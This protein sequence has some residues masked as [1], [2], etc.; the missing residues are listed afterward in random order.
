MR[1]NLRPRHQVRRLAP[2]ALLGLSPLLFAT[3]GPPAPAG[4][5]A[6]PTGPTGTIS[7]TVND[8]ENHTAQV[9]LVNA[10]GSG[11]HQLTG[12]DFSY[13]NWSTDGQRLVM[14]GDSVPAA[15]PPDPLHV[16][17]DVDPATG[18]KRLLPY[19]DTDLTVICYRWSPDRTRLAC[20]AWNDAD[21]TDPRQGMY[22]V[23]ASDGQDFAPIFWEGPGRVGEGTLNG[24]SPDGRTFLF[25]R[26]D[27]D[28]DQGLYLAAVDG[29]WVRRLTPSALLVNSGE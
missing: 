14:I 26:Q 27:G 15:T 25:N 21:D 29:S 22:T 16:G 7:F 17:W 24:Y 13:A 18:Q 8:E 4:V 9:W 12:F 23:R 11:E 3:S 6:R 10:D 19:P 2:L 20:E 1:T 5:P 28:D